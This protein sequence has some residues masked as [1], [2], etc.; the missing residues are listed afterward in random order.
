M[1]DVPSNLPE[2]SA[3]GILAKTPLPHLLVYALDQQLSGTIELAT[4]PSGSGGTILVI[5]G[6]PVKARTTE[7]T[8]Y[9]G[10]VLL[11]LGVLT[12]EQLNLSLRTLSEQ[13][14]LHGQI[15]LEAG[16]INEEQL[17]LGLRAQLVRKLQ[18][19][20]HLPADTVFHY[21][22]SFDGLASYGGDGHVGID[23]APIIW[24][25]IREE[26]PWEHVHAALTK[27]GAAGVRLAPS[28]ETARFSF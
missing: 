26:P 18:A 17:E 4:P 14:R 11:E 7:P 16:Y 25:A 27:V 22:D 9:L 19:L 20:V 2:P 21:Y 1:V 5:E 3:Q 12:E 10:R 24:A 28:A 15:L 6:Q 13:K 8:S 23:P